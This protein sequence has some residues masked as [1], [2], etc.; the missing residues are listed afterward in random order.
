MLQAGT[1]L[2]N[3]ALPTLPSHLY[4]TPTT[5]WSFANQDQFGTKG[6]KDVPLGVTGSNFKRKSTFSN[7]QEN[8]QSDKISLN[9]RI[10]YRWRNS[11]EEQL[12]EHYL[13]QMV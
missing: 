11:E 7:N 5:F 10:D 4:K 13:I 9:K 1:N 6:R 3:T 8:S 12:L 2:D